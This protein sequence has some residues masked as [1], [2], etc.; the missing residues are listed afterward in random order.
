ML[1]GA[2]SAVQPAGVAIATEFA[3]PLQKV[4]PVGRRLPEQKEK[5]GPKK[6]LGLA[7]I[8]GTWDI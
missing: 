7:T 6:V 1:K 2:Q 5:T 8:H 3:K 4:I